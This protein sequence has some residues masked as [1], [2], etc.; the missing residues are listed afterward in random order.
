MTQGFDHHDFLVQSHARITVKHD[1]RVRVFL[2]RIRILSLFLMSASAER[3][4]CSTSQQ[5]LKSIEDRI[6]LSFHLLRT[7]SCVPAVCLLHEHS[8][9]KENLFPCFALLE[10][11]PPPDPCWLLM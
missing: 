3:E 11:F 1:F 4:N 9:Q 8:P 10:H 7:F 2:F 5:T 6:A